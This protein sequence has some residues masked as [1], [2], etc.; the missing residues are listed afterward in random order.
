[1]NLPEPT[2]VFAAY[3]R[4]ADERQRVYQR[5]AA[6]A[7]GPWTDDP[8]LRAY[9]FTNAYRVLDRVTQTLLREVVP[10]ERHTSHEDL[11]VRVLLFK[12]FNRTATWQHL[13][14]QL[15]QPSGSAFDADEV[16]AALDDRRAAGEKVYSNAYVMP[17][18]PG[19]QGPK[20]HGHLRLLERMLEDGLPAR[21]AAEGTLDGTYRLLVAYSGLG[22]FLA[23]Q[24]AVDL[25]YTALTDT[26][27]DGFV[28]P[29]P[30]ALDGIAKCFQGRLPTS[31]TE[32][33]L[34][35]ARTQDRWFAQ[36]GLEFERLGQRPLKPID[37]QN[38][39]CEISKY[40]R[41]AFPSVPG[42]LGRTR[43]KQRYRPAGQLAPA[44]LPAKW[45][46]APEQTAAV[47]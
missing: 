43:I 38:L 31:P 41:A 35:L 9:R 20:H 40:A 11:F 39:F 6:G 1:M 22:P 24:F 23:F 14:E 47:A 8:I 33:I 28:V 30:G 26:D 32:L 45:R 44:V 42:R 27:E 25:N 21:I 19:E 13:V 2:P 10:D 4:F 17:P 12:L 5:R 36:Q 15:G 18:V 3:W 37:M 16:I 34:T 29:G 46:A 7:A